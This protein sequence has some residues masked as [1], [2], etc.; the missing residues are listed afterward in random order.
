VEEETVEGKKGDWNEPGIT[1]DERAR[2][3]MEEAKKGKEL[4]PFPIHYS[5]PSPPSSFP[6]QS[7]IPFHDTFKKE[8]DTKREIGSLL[9]HFFSERDSSLQQAMEEEEKK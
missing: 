5:S 4:P 3:Y 1:P 9:H 8:E 7:S 2:R 6:S